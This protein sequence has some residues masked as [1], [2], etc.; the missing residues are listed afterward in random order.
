MSRRVI[1]PAVAILASGLLASCEGKLPEGVRYLPG[2]TVDTYYAL[3]GVWVQ[4][5]GVVTQGTQFSWGKA[6][7]VPQWSTD[8]D[9]GAQPAFMTV[10]GGLFE[11][12][13]VA[14][15][16]RGVY[17]LR[18][19]W[20]RSSVEETPVNLVVHVNEKGSMWWEP[21]GIMGQG[22]DVVYVKIDGPKR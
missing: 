14:T 7:H 15:A 20:K 21:N 6:Q 11:I 9:L 8:I 17:T 10:P 1:L 18:M 12:R 3:C 2:L 16:E 22:R 4:N 19:A 5:P 13:E